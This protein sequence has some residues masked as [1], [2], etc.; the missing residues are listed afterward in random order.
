MKCD[1]CDSDNNQVVRVNSWTVCHDCSS[2]GV[3]QTAIEAH[4][5]PIGAADPINAGSAEAKA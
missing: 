5:A 1:L 4:D 3:L 2:N